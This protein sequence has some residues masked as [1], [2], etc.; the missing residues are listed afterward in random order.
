MLSA[1]HDYGTIKV[2]EGGELFIVHD[3]GIPAGIKDL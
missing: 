1:E 3:E 2:H